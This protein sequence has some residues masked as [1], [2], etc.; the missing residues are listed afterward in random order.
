[1]RRSTIINETASVG[2]DTFTH[3]HSW[4]F[5]VYDGQS[6]LQSHHTNFLTQQA[7]EVGRRQDR[8]APDVNA[9]LTQSTHCQGP[10][11][12]QWLCTP[13]PAVFPPRDTCTPATLL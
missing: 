5:H 10:A 12:T 7:A 3:H 9:A 8:P 11:K 1:M 2:D 6:T 4:T 13:T